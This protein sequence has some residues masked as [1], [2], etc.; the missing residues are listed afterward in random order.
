MFF[1]SSKCRYLENRVRGP[2][3]SLKMSPSDRAHDFL[4]TFYSIMR[5]SRTVSEIDG[6]FSWKSQNFPNPCILCPRWTGS[7]WNWVSAPRSKKTRMMGLLSRQR[8][9]TIYSVVCVECTNVT[10]RQTDTGPQQWPRLRIASRGK[11]FI[12]FE[13][14]SDHMLSWS[15]INSWWNG[16]IGTRWP[17]WMNECF[18]NQYQSILSFFQLSRRIS[19]GGFQVIRWQRLRS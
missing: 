9:L 8:S 14:D 18:I 2:S 10:D 19:L 4:L 15:W 3:R 6:D 11:N 13:S 1:F 17:E 5:L 12:A 16:M 7:P